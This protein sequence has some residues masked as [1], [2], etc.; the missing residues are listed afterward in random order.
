MTILPGQTACLR[1]LVPEIPPPGA[2]PT[3]DTAGIL[4]PIVNVIASLQAAEAIKILS[5]NLQAVNR[6]L[7]V[8]DVWDN[9][10]RQVK[11]DTLRSRSECP[12]CKH[13]QYAYLTGQRGSH[14]ATIC[15][16]NA[17]QLS[18]SEGQAVDLAE[19]AKRL[20][21]IGQVVSN[22]YLLRLS[23]GQYRL[24]VFTDGRTIVQGT[25]DVSEARTVYA[26]YIGG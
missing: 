6:D 3:C 12:T 7:S 4:A 9:R 22:A 10:M 14:A 8:I 11:L 20:K 15:G 25:D 2:T 23:I 13:G 21:R 1:C 16:R 19:L 5:G 17:V 18:T 24:T 26:R